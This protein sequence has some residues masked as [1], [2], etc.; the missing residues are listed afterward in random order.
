MHDVEVK[1]ANEDR[2]SAVVLE[3]VTVADFVHV[4][5]QHASGVPVFTLKNVEDFSVN[6]SRPLP[7]TYIEKAEQKTL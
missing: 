6:I 2:R 7:D 4:K 5:L 3:D 1:Y